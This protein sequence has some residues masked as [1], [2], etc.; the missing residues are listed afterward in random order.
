VTPESLGKHRLAYR[1]LIALSPRSHQDRFGEAQV[2]LFGDLLESGEPP[3]RLWARAL[4][5]LFR[6][7]KEN[8]EET[9]GHLTRLALGV[10]SIAP[11]VL[12]V[13]VGWV[14]IDEFGDV[15]GWLPLVAVALLAQGG[16]TLLWLSG[17]LGRWQRLATDGFVVGEGAALLIGV[18]AVTVTAATENPADPEYGPILVCMVAGILGFIGLLALLASVRSVLPTTDRSVPH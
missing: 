8:K 13:V 9:V 14:A 2:T 3:L 17:R 15:P 1:R 7:Y 6:V 5:D 12:A 4:P 11:L 18:L 16:F 10:I